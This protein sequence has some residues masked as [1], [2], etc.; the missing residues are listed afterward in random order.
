MQNK[1]T[2]ILAAIFKSVWHTDFRIKLKL[3]YQKVS[4][5]KVESKTSTNAS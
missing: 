3:V 5:F 1:M 4:N 2:T